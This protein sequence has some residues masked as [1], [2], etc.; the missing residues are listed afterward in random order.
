MLCPAADCDIVDTWTVGGLRGTGSHDVVVQDRFVP[1]LYASFHT[2]PLVL[3][4]SR[5]KLPHLSRLVPGLGGMALGIAR[6][7]IEALIELAGEKRHE[8]TSQS[9]AED[10]GAQTRLS[11]AEALVCSARRS[12]AGRGL[13]ANGFTRHCHRRTSRRARLSNRRTNTRP[14]ARR[15]T[16]LLDFRP[17]WRG[18][19][20]KE[21]VVAD[22]VRHCMDHDR[23][24]QAYRWYVR[25]KRSSELEGSPRRSSA[26]RIDYLCNA[27]YSRL[28][29]TQQAEWKLL[30]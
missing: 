28:P 8:R 12:R 19:E 6:S 3:T 4:D 24:H 25:E 17:S 23:I 29:R 9:M 10:R 1:A 26:P 15:R 27:A 11:Q 21:T 14:P 5:Y 20:R 7:A 2:A 16:R 18:E 22:E 30:E 13:T